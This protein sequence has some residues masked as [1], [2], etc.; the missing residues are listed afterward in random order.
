MSEQLLEE[1]AAN[2]AKTGEWNYHWHWEQT[3][4]GYS[5]TVKG[6]RKA[7]KDIQ[8]AIEYYQNALGRAVP[9]L[10]EVRA[11]IKQMEDNE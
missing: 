1:R 6:W 10:N 2:A 3:P 9:V 7:A 8:D 4:S 5:Y 11:K